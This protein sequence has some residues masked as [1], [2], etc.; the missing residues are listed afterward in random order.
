MQM[1][2]W[3]GKILYVNLE[4]QTTYIED[5]SKYLDYIGGRGINQYLLFQMLDPKV[6]PLDPENVVIL[7][8]GPMV[9]TLIPASCRLSVDFKNVVS[10]GVGSSNCG[11]QFAAEMKFAGYDHIVITGRSKEHVYLYIHNEKVFFRSAQ[12]LWGKTT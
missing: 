9:G 4:K 12:Q 6:K 3:A 2:G 11:G 7:G 10:G 8:S 1:Y 5:T